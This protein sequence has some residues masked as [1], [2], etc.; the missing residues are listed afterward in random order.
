MGAIL[1]AIA[2]KM[3]SQKVMI[4]ILLRLGDWLVDRSENDLDNK[5]WAEVKKALV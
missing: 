5:V 3:L 1:G 4:A 2:T